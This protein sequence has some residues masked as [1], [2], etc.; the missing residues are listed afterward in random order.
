[1]YINITH[2]RPDNPLL[3]GEA[4]GQLIAK[5]SSN[6][7]PQLFSQGTRSKF[8]CRESERRTSSCDLQ[9][10][11]RRALHHSA[12][13]FEHIGGSSGDVGELPMRIAAVG[14]EEQGGERADGGGGRG[15]AQ[16]T[17]RRERGA[18]GGPGVAAHG[19]AHDCH[20]R[21][22]AGSQGAGHAVQLRRR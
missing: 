12:P 2:S 17:W 9:P 18:P 7:F 14:G 15:R 21:P 6:P 4:Q 20:A 3:V 13:G 22:V 11:L 1:M 10:D 5:V 16:P 19:G 8:S